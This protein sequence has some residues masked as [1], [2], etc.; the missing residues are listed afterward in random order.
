MGADRITRRVHLATGVT[1]PYFEQG[2]RR[3]TAVLLLHP[4]TESSGCFD[5]LLRAV[6][7]TL[8]VLAMDQRG[9]GDADKPADGYDLVSFADDI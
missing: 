3:A 2:D 7:P 8:R 5:R 6:P 1:V 4:W 9:H